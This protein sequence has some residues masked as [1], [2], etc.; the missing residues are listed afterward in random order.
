MSLYSAEK[1]Y[2]NKTWVH[3]TELSKQKMSDYNNASI[4]ETL[5][6]FNVS[7]FLIQVSNIIALSL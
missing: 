2:Q 1:M 6:F 5:F 7:L 4:V 3:L